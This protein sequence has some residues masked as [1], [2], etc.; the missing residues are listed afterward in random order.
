MTIYEILS[1][2]KAMTFGTFVLVNK[3]LSE[4]VPSAGLL[5]SNDLFPDLADWKFVGNC[6]E[7]NSYFWVCGYCGT[8]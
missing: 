8:L 7:L 4:G 2:Y 6:P 3:Q 5:N 1:F